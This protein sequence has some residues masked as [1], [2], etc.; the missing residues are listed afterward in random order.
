MRPIPPMLR[1]EI[2]NDPFYGKCARKVLLDDHV[3]RGSITWEHAIIFAGKQLN[4]KWAIIPLCA[5]AHSV[6]EFQDGGCLDKEINHW[7]ALN[8]A[9]DQELED[10]SRAEDYKRKRDYLN[11]KYKRNGHTE[12]GM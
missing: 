10:I 5:F 9:T 1:E 8:R 12:G 2:K 6:N 11:E 7:I 4:E 3:C